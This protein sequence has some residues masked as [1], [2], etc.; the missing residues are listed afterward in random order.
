MQD[1]PQLSSWR[2]TIRRTSLG[3]RYS[4]HLK[5]P[6]SEEA[7]EAGEHLLDDVIVL[8]DG[9]LPAQLARHAVT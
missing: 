1:A 3:T 5:M 7:P 9:Q 6:A 2:V 4:L 8:L